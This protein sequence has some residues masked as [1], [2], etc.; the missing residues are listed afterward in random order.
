MNRRHY[1]VGLKR[2]MLCY[3]IQKIKVKLKFK[4]VCSMVTVKYFLP[5]RAIW[6]MVGA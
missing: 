4:K 6:S 5:L 1:A 2:G 3:V